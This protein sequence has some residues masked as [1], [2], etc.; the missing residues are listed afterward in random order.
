[1][2]E[3]GGTGGCRGSAPPDAVDPFP[4]EDH[5]C[6][7][8]YN[9]FDAERR[10]PKLLGC[11]HTF[12]RECLDALHSREGRGW[13][14]GCPVCRHR[15]PVPEY[16]ID[17]LPDNSAVAEA[18]RFKKPERASPPT[19]DAPTAAAAPPRGR[20]GRGGGCPLTLRRVAFTSGLVCAIF[21]SVCAVALLLLGLVF[22]HNFGG[23][24]WPVG[25]TCLFLAGVLEM[26]S[27]ILTWLLCTVKFQ[28]ETRQFSSPGDN[29][30]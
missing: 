14:V 30:T 20:G 2:A 29:V 22:A 24:S 5:E 8:C 26:A 10:A 4:N 3:A 17:N 11:A 13:R 19:A 18:V 25:P 6:K 27:L 12:C 9:D 16:R 7:I 1:M 15:T 23:A 21:C 28:P